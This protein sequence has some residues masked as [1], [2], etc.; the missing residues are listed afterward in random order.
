M[1]RPVLNQYGTRFVPYFH[2]CLIHTS[3]THTSTPNL[4]IM[5]KI[6]QQNCRGG[7]YA[8]PPLRSSVCL[9][10]AV[11]V[12]CCHGCLETDTTHLRCS[13]HPRLLKMSTTPDPPP[14]PQKRK[15]LQKYRR[16]WEEAHPW[17]DS[18][19]DNIVFIYGHLKNKSY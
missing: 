9:C 3:V 5:S 13:Q 18:V 10:L 15:R 4:T 12:R 19:S 17:L 11:C 7:I 14:R 16:E 1:L 6:K 8:G 2:K